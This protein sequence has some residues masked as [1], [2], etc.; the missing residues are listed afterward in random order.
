M[1]I[2][3]GAQFM[4]IVTK[5]SLL[6]LLAAVVLP[7]AASAQESRLTLSFTPAVVAE[8]GDSQLALAGNAS[9]RFTEHFA[10]EGDVTWI[11]AAA[12]GVRDRNFGF[13]PRVTGATVQTVLQNVGA[14]FGGGRNPRMPAFD[15]RGLG[16]IIG[17][18]TGG[19][20]T[21]PA[22]ATTDGQTWIGTMGVRYEPGVQTARFR[23]YVSGG[24]GINFTDQRLDL[25]AVSSP[26]TY[27]DSHS[28]LALS[29]GGGA[30]IHLGGALWLNADA[31]YFHL[32]RDRDLMRLGGGVT[33]KF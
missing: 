16:N 30:N 1:D 22:R 10:F 11:D 3:L 18:V 2:V 12:G 8:S 32:S 20:S 9:Y 13:D 31:K 33:L 4:K 26:V 19:I 5:S 17:G 23:P 14:I 6:A 24:L 28:G 25:S 27:D 7:M 15:G 21:L 29:A